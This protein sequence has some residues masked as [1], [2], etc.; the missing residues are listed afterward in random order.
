M[1]VGEGED[2]TSWEITIDACVCV[3]VCSVT[4]SCLTFWDPTGC[5]SP[6]FLFLHYLLEFSQMLKYILLCK[7]GS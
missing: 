5:S 2:V 7:I 3:F 6:G 1:D 4:K